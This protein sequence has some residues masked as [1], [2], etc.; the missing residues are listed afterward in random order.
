LNNQNH[1]II[2][3]VLVLTTML[4]H[5]QVILLRRNDDS[6]INVAQLGTQKTHAS[7]VPQAQ[8]RTICSTPIKG[9]RSPSKLGLQAPNTASPALVW[10]LDLLPN[11]AP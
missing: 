6:R 3:H 8:I 4:D 11:N 10:C 2:L 7:F 1:F 9:S 5:S